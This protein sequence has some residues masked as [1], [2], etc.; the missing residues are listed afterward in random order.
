MRREGS[1]ARRER[2]GEGSRLGW[3]SLQRRR[4]DTA[5][6]G[7]CSE[8]KGQRL[9]SRVIYWRAGF[10]RCGGRGTW[11][12]FSPLTGVSL[13]IDGSCGPKRAGP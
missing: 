2:P 1:R 12:A 3:R 6:L 8:P 13:M 7:V 10:S 11:E 4:D 9:A 5:L